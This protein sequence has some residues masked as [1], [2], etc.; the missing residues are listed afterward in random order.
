MAIQA[1]NTRL[2]LIRFQRPDV[3]FSREWLNDPALIYGKAN[4]RYIT[5][6]VVE[7]PTSVQIGGK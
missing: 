4:F 2:K 3:D 7:G 5:S 1:A 6:L